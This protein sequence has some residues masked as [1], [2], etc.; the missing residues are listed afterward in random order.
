MDILDCAEFYAFDQGSIQFQYTRVLLHQDSRIFLGQYSGRKIAIGTNLDI[1]RLSAIQEILPEMYRPQDL[2]NYIHASKF[3]VEG[4][5]I[6]RPNLLQFDGTPHLAELTLVDL[7]ACE[8]LHQHPHV[9]I[10]RYLGCLKEGG[11]VAAL[12]FSKYKETLMDKLNPE[13]LSKVDFINTAAEARSAASQRY[14]PR[15][16]QAVRHIHEL[17]L[18]HND[19][20]PENIMIDSE[21]NPVLIDFDSCVEQGSS[22]SGIKRTLGWY[23]ESIEV[24]R[25]E[26][27]WRALKEIRTWLEAS[28]AESFSFGY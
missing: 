19:I 1:E 21:D 2:G 27:D 9:N 11:K 26:N 23:D 22:L 7:K 17:G 20:N 3:Q 8:I 13:G 4:V 10:A 6:K 15:I 5:H 12:C 24:S 16:E 14:L 18:A 28:T 25:P